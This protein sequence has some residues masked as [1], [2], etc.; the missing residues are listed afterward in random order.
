[1]D[2]LQE[3]RK[4]MINYLAHSGSARWSSQAVKDADYKISY[5]QYNKMTTMELLSEFAEEQRKS[6]QDSMSGY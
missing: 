1:M 2:E 5:A 6:G 4:T 3:V